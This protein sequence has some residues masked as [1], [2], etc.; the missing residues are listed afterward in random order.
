MNLYAFWKYDLPPFLLG[1]IVEL[2]NEDG[3]VKIKDRYDGMRFKPTVLVPLEKG[4]VLQQKLDEAQTVYEKETKAAKEKLL[5]V[6]NGIKQ[7]NITN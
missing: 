4:L 5:N 7:Q 6:V 1:G 3:Y 2:I